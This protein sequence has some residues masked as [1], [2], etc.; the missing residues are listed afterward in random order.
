MSS[1]IG[2]VITLFRFIIMFYGTDNISLV[3]LDI[4]HIQSKCGEYPKILCGILL[5]PQ[6]IV[7]DLNKVMVLQENM[8]FYYLCSARCVILFDNTY[9]NKN[10]INSIKTCRP[11]AITLL[12][13]TSI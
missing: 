5:V 11:Y 12:S 6:N 8:I 1:Q 13:W 2:N 10:R 9:S 7:M 4:P 3:F